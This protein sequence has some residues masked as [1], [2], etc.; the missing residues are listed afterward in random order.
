MFTVKKPVLFPVEVIEGNC[1]VCGKFTEGRDVIK[2]IYNGSKYILCGVKCYK[3][4]FK[5]LEGNKNNRRI[6]K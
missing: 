6:E 5:R 1:E 4:L 3:K 2:L